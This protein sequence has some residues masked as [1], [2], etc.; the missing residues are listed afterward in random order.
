MRKKIISLLVALCLI[1]TTGTPVGHSGSSLASAQQSSCPANQIMRVTLTPIPDTFN[2][3][4]AHG[5]ADFIVAWAQ[6]LSLTPFPD[7]PNGSLDWPQAITDWY[8]SNSN[9][10]EWTFNVKPGMKWSDGTNVTSQDILNTY[11]PSYAL[12]PNYDILNLHTEIVSSYAVN[13]SAAVFVLNK[14]DAHLPEEMS[15][16]I[17]FSIE[18][19]SDIRQGPAYNMFSQDVA[20]GPFFNTGYTSGS[21]T[22]VMLRNPYFKPESN[23]CELDV[24]FVESSAYMTQFLVSG[25]TDLTWPLA[26]GA[27]ASTLNLP[28]IHIYDE[29]GEWETAIQYNVTT[30]PYNVTA[31]RQALAYAIND[32]AVV[33]SMFGYGV[34]A[35]NATGG[36]P[37]NFPWYDPNQPNYAYNPQKALQLLESIGFKQVNGVLEYP[38]GTAVSLTLWTDTA[39]PQD[40]PAATPIVNDLQALGMQVSVQTV[41][42]QALSAD[43]A[44]NAFNIQ[45]ELIL[46]SSGGPVFSDLWLDGQ[47]PCDVMGTPGCHKTLIWPQSALNEYNSNL[48]ALDSTANITQERVYLNNIQ[49]IQAQYLPVLPVA[50]PDLIV[51]YSTAHFTGW[52]SPPALISLQPERFNDTLFA[53]LQPVSSSSSSTSQSGTS[54]LTTVVTTIATTNVSTTYLIAAI[55]IAVIVVAV[56]AALVVRAR[57]RP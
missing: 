25:Q 3:L 48:T 19:P 14:S 55:V 10:T 26:P 40:I 56:S 20:D 24:N 57:R 16:Y 9:Y 34:P 11:S 8:S 27:I 29:K 39:K 49:E 7:E 47:P 36:V 46:Y 38:N 35:N 33:Q 12:N 43:Y 1:F 22:L 31:F 53:G 30:Y 42:V 15:N 50:Y 28:N 32:S 5:S 4:D 6:K 54:Q 23:I 17:S 44:S 2:D 18:P 51:G 41:S 21:T 45:N 37:P 13:S 52:P